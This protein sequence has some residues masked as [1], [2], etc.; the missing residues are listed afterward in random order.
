MEAEYLMLTHFLGVGGPEV[1]RKLRNHLLHVQREDGTWGQFYGAPGDLSTSTECYFALKLAGM[2]AADPRMCAAREFILSKGGVTEARVFTKI[3]LS[4]F[5]QYDWGGVP[6]LPP[7]LML[8]PKWFPVNLYE[9]SSWARSTIVPLL[10]IFDRK[11]VRPVAPRAAI[12]ELYTLPPSET[13]YSIKRP[14]K[15]IGW[16]SLFYAGGRGSQPAGETPMEADSGAGCKEGR[17]VDS[18]RSSG[19]GWK[20]GGNSA[21][22]GLLPDGAERAW[23][24][25]RP[26]GDEARHRGVRGF[27]GGG[28]RQA[29]RAGV[30]F[31]GVG[32][33]PSADGLLEAGVSPEDPALRK[34]GDWLVRGQILTGGDWQVKASDIPPGGW[35]FEFHNNQYPDLD[36]TSE[37]VM[38]LDRLALEDEDAKREAIDRA[39][40]WLLGMQSSNGGWAAFDKNN[41]RALLAKI[42]FSDFGE[43]I[44]PPSVDVT[45]HIL[46]MLGQLGYN[47]GNP[48][49]ARALDY[50][51]AEQEADGP[52]FGPLGRELHIRHGRGASR[53]EIAGHRHDD[54]ARA[55]GGALADRPPERGWRLG[56]ELRIL[57]GSSIPRG[58]VPAHRLK[59]PGLFWRFLRRAR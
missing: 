23:L 56:R 1:W 57:R 50:I 7:E 8:L 59:P 36:D 45:A 3:W 9:F 48:Q 25:S 53:A 47:A 6:S 20:L 49:V 33:L 24:P 22:V 52:W 11:P 5:G 55:E 46:E 30:R 34:A 17:A 42:P 41:T 38:A 13:D 37:V 54:E 10:I 14:D 18:P 26:P 21:A 40:R 58:A 43:T 44:D 51:F 39:V 31:A 29:A 16:E 19:G 15:L 28:G 32:Y 4:L 27:F 12:P 35:A 2:D